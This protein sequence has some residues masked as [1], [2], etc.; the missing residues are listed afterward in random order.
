MEI[1]KDTYIKLVRFDVTK[2]HQLTFE[3]ITAQTNFFLESLNGVEL[4]ASSYQRKDFKVR[5]PA[6][7]DAIEKYNYMVCRNLPY[8]FKYYYFYITNMEYV[9]DE[10][11]D[12]FIKLD[13]FQTYQFDFIYK[14]C[15]IEREHVNDDIRGRYTVPEGIEKGDYIIN[16][17]I[18]FPE[19]QRYLFI[20]RVTKDLNATVHY[21]TGIGEIFGS[22]CLYACRYYSDVAMLIQA[23][24]QNPDLDPEKDIQNIYYVPMS[25]VDFGQTPVVDPD[26]EFIIML[27]NEIRVKKINDSISKAT[28]LD[29]YTPVNKKLLTEEYCYLM[30]SN[31]NGGNVNLAY[32]NFKTSDCE[33]VA[34]CVPVEGGSARLTPLQY[35]N[36]ATQDYAFLPF[37]V[38]SGKYYITDFSLDNYKIWLANNMTNIATLNVANAG[39]LALGVGQL[40]ASLY[41]GG[42][43]LS[44]AVGN[45]TSPIMRYMSMAQTIYEKSKI[46]SSTSGQVTNGG[47]LNA[48]GRNV[49]SYYRMSIKSEYARKIDKF[50][51][52]FGYKINELKIP[53]ITGR[54]NWNYVKTI[55]AIVESETVPEK[56]LNEFKQM[57]NNGITFWHNFATFKDYSQ[58]NNIV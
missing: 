58:S 39:Q 29:G 8:N 25:F 19:M 42:I 40:G 16:E 46:P 11:T 24:E 34:S 36:T 45:I 17:R 2:E 7:I 26:A 53:N 44:E 54:V 23:Y 18:Q 51:S 38:S 10:L 31:E 52:V 14:Q 1:T 33:F 55:E 5:F 32:E 57:L 50:F 12:V 6:G 30:T 35:G 37:S 22:G 9:N 49:F 21:G 41:S 56:Y 47:I 4:Q 13:V 27:N 15:M 20:V 3:N 43:G 28:S 48:E